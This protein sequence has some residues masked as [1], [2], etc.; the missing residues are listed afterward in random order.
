MPIILEDA[1]VRSDMSNACDLSGSA[2]Q[3]MEIHRRCTPVS[4]DFDQRTMHFIPTGSW[5]MLSPCTLLLFFPFFGFT[6]A[7]KVFYSCLRSSQSH[8]CQRCA[9][10]RRLVNRIQT[11]IRGSSD[12]IGWLKR[13]PDLA[14]VEDKTSRFLQLL[15]LISNGVHKLPNSFVY[16]LVPGLFSNHGP[17]YFVDT[18]KHFSKLGL[19][20]HI[21][22]IHSEASVETNAVELKNYIEELY[23]GCGK[24][25]MLLG[26][27]KGGVDAAAAVA[28]FWPDLKEKVAG[29]VVAQSPYG[30][31]PI[32]SDI[33]RE[34]QI[35]DLETRRV[36]ELLI[37]KIIKGDIRSLEDLT[38][39]KRREFLAQHPLPSDFP[40]VSFHTE[41]SI[42]PG[43]LSTM[44]HIAHAELTWPPL[45]ANPGA[46]FEP[47]P[48]TKLPVI[49]PLAAAMA[50][51]ALHL[52][53]RY[54]EKSD[55]LVIRKDAEVPGSVV[56]RPDRKL[57]HAWMVYSGSHKEI[58][59]CD[60]SQMCEALL[61]LLLEVIEKENGGYVHQ[62]ES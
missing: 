55:G 6:F 21:A 34:G 1:V 32:A 16:L 30:G 40:T 60:P 27:S 33:L 62:F 51:C 24:Q 10:I 39:D 11:T 7:W 2:D 47:A 29:L 26:H 37:C 5:S 20:C 36:M 50:V 48:A 23:W 44:S 12:D 53:L 31:S 61:T 42:A 46:A 59:K 15:G 57:D 4:E 52:E 3:R 49:I 41:A 13:M 17:L 25:V 54:G 35:A 43:V 28:K 8:L 45:S 58:K 22:K 38:Y 9:H 56:V 18:K 14:P 19:V